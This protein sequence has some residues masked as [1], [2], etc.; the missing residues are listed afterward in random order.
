MVVVGLLCLP[1][2]AF[3]GVFGHWMRRKRS[4]HTKATQRDPVKNHAQIRGILQGLFPNAEMPPAMSDSTY[5]YA[6][7][8]WIEGKLFRFYKRVMVWAGLMRWMPTH[9]CENKSRIF[10]CCACACWGKHAN[11][12]KDA[13]SIAV[14][15]VSYKRDAGGWHSINVALVGA[16]FSTMFIEPQGPSVVRLS[17]AEI[18]SVRFVEM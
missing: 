3:C 2:G 8:D 1:D 11:P 12:Q 4:G 15:R 18:D 17:N 7:A 5:E 13:Q 14:G 9:D 16:R 6:D 10:M